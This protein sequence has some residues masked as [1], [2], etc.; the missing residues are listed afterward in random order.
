MNGSINAAFAGA[1]LNITYQNVHLDGQGHTI[2]GVA[3]N[4]TGIAVSGGAN[5][6]ITNVTLERWGDGIAVEEAADVTLK[7]V[8]VPTTA[9]TALNLTSNTTASATDL[10]VGAAQG[11]SGVVSFDASVPGDGRVAVRPPTQMV[12]PPPNN[13]S[14]FS[15]VDVRV[16]NSSITNL[17]LPYTDTAASNL[18]ES[19][20]RG[21]TH[22]GSDWTS[23]PGSVNTTTNHVI[24]SA[25]ATTPGWETL[26]PLGTATD[27]EPTYSIS[28]SPTDVGIL[29]PY[30]TSVNITNTGAPKLDR[31]DL[32]RNEMVTSSAVVNLP[33]NGTTT[34]TL[35]E[36]FHHASPR[37]AYFEVS[38]LGTNESA[39]VS[40]TDPTT[41]QP[42]W[43]S[44][45]LQ[46]DN[47]NYDPGLQPPRPPLEM[48]GIRLCHPGV[49]SR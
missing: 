40:L 41:D 42:E 22:N 49:V 6:T 45:H 25:P 5:V 34:H 3:S 47:D 20:L 30:T 33:A 29:D 1:C 32:T 19:T 17:T 23:R 11:Q 31:I 24:V 36:S 38:I 9:S 26:A 4:G 7:N 16:S 13:R 14:V 12:A 46:P 43:Q 10:N 15:F 39:M 35:N 48:G 8:T 37:T 28:V 44:W 21:W 2:D 27:A 18:E